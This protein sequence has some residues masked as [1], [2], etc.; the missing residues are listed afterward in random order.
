M[1][2]RPRSLSADQV[3]MARTLIANPNL[4]TRQV[5]RQ[6]GVHSATLY[7]SLSAP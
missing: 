5:V 3:E 2:G 7:R 1:P 4:S 6:L